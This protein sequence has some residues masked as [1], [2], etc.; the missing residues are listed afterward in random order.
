MS[1]CKQC[2]CEQVCRF[3]DG[4]NLCCKEDY[5]C[6]H[7]RSTANVVEIVRCKD[8]VYCKLEYPVKAIGE[9]AIEGYFCYLNQKYLSPTDFCSYGERK[10]S[11]AK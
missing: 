11:V 10:D 9:E 2:I 6:P 7:Y 5:E 4:H 8:C 1:K 3:N